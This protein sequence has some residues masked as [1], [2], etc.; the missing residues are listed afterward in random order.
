[1]KRCYDCGLTKSTGE[2]S[3][4]KAKKDGL[5]SECR[6]CAARRHRDYHKQ[7]HQR[8]LRTMRK[9]H[10][11]HTGEA[12]ARSDKFREKNPGRDSEYYRRRDPR[13]V[14]ARSVAR[15]AIKQGRLIREPCEV[16]GAKKTQAHHDDYDQPLEVR[17]LCRKHHEQVH[18]KCTEEAEGRYA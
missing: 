12:R 11:E 8:R 10:K 5:S 18:W 7:N 13:K 1:M 9:Y 17:W 3:R 14:K 6:A 15:H 2:F 4:N 16:C